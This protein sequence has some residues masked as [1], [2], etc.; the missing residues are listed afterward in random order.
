[1]KKTL[2]EKTSDNLVKA[3]LKNKIILSIPKKFTK[4]LE[5]VNKKN[6]S[7][8]FFTGFPYYPQSL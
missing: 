5:I 8:I 3:F 1:M 6:F 4:K 2:I 7:L